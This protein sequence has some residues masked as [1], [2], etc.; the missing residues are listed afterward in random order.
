MDQQRSPSPLLPVLFQSRT[1]P[2]SMRISR[3]C[4][5]LSPTAIR[6]PPPKVLVS[7]S[8]LPWNSR[9]Q[10]GSRARSSLLACTAR[11]AI[12]GRRAAASLRRE[13][14]GAPLRHMASGRMEQT[15]G[16]HMGHAASAVQ[17]GTWTRAP[18]THSGKQDNSACSHKQTYERSGKCSFLPS[19]R[20]ELS[21]WNV[22]SWMLWIWNDAVVVYWS[23][24]LFMGMKRLNLGSLTS[25]HS[26]WNAN[27]F[28]TFADFAYYA[29]AL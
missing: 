10:E 18:Q 13:K 8:N 16:L 17:W 3:V 9:R 11:A 29:F 4:C 5:R 1:L 21:R 14:P 2:T 28:P 7:T 15:P 23:H 25:W 24:D 22:L 12:C 20:L 27:V 19:P 6:T 26:S